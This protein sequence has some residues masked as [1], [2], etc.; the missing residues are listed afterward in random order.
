[1]TD[2]L[3]GAAHADRLTD[4][5]RRSGALARGRVRH[6]AVASSRDTILSRIIRLDLCC[7]RS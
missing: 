7:G 5:L 2:S 4:A 3:P 1:M 6:V